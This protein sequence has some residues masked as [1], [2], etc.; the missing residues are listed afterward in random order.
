MPRIVVS[1]PHRLKPE[2]AKRRVGTL[3]ERVHR[4]GGTW[5]EH[6]ISPSSMFLKGRLHGQ[7]VTGEV[8]IEACLLKATVNLPWT[9]AMVASRIK[10]AL[11]EAAHT[12][13][14]ES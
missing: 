11:E 10:H 7:F 13:L 4:L 5:S 14:T 3:I 8:A 1:I 9:L 12:A 2:E 6:W